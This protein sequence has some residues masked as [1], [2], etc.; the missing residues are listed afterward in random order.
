[1]F[2]SIFLT[3]KTQRKCNRKYTN[4]N[5]NINNTVPRSAS[6][7]LQFCSMRFYDSFFFCTFVWLYTRENFDIGPLSNTD[8]DISTVTHTAVYWQMNAFNVSKTIL[9]GIIQFES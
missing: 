7:D 3:T 9:S 1:M 8:I 4:E 2:V 5:N 6:V